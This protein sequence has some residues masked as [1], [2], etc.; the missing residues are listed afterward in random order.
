MVVNTLHAQS[1][2]DPILDVKLLWDFQVLLLIHELI[3]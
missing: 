3:Q 2:V 1:C